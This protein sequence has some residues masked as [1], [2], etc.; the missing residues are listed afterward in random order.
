ML[1]TD[2]APHNPDNSPKDGFERDAVEALI[3]GQNYYEKVEM[4]EGK[5]YLRSATSV[6]A[7]MEGCT[8]CHPGKKVGDLLG[9]ISYRI[10]VN[11]YFD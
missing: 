2:E 5:Y 7:V 8:I 4:V 1:G 6:I 9:A 3:S 10:S 11:E